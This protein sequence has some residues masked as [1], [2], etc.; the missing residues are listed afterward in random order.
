M[1]NKASLLTIALFLV[2]STTSTAID[3]TKIL[4]Q[5]PDTYGSFNGLLTATKLSEEINKRQT[6]TILALDNDSIDTL[7]GRP[8]E[9]VTKMLSNHVI[10]DYF[11]EAKLKELK[12][13]QSTT[14]TTLYQ[15]TGDAQNSQGF[16]NISVMGSGEVMFGSAVKNS[17]LNSKLLGSVMNKPYTVSVLHVSEPIIALGSENGPLAATPP[18]KNDSNAPA[19]RAPAKSAPTTPPLKK[20]PA[21][22][23]S[24]MN[25]VGSKIGVAVVMGLVMN[26]MGF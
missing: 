9:E 23:G 17:P 6:V 11:D 26:L 3:I 15:T 5:Y 20:P 24:S 22:S 18:P 12:A 16:L 10:L 25:T 13:K 2:F 8:I 19:K 4:D 7:S 14:V 1:A 21:E